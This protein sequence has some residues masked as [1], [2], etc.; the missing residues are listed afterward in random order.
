MERLY[1]HNVF[2]ISLIVSVAVSAVI[3]GSD[4][5]ASL[6]QLR[7]ASMEVLLLA[8]LALGLEIC[9]RGMRLQ[10]MTTIWQ[11]QVGFLR[12][13]QINLAG[14]FANAVT[15]A[16]VGG[17]PVRG[18]QLV[19]SKMTIEEATATIIG[20]R[21]TDHLALAVLSVVL[22]ALSFDSFEGSGRY[23]AYM[24]G[25]SLIGCVTCYIYFRG[26]SKFRQGTTGRYLGTLF[27]RLIGKDSLPGRYAL[28][29][30]QFWSRLR[31]DLRHMVTLG[32]KRFLLCGLLAI[33]NQS[34]RTCIP[35][36]LAYG[37][38]LD[39][40]VA[41]CVLWILAKRYGLDSMPIPGANG[42]TETA[43]LW[44]FG[45]Y[46][47]VSSL[48]PFLILWRFFSYYAYL[49]LG[50][51]VTVWMV[52]NRTSGLKSYLTSIGN[53]QNPVAEESA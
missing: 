25:A 2:I 9:L 33:L 1:R 26:N 23:L 52:G 43:F 17:G 10:V 45:K 5:E 48:A 44:Y 42:I 53:D 46:T 50:G 37:L 49:I 4:L 35:V 47:A 41:A 21:L 16:S 31:Q 29:F 22:L 13:I 36:I 6:V 20:E 12:A 8:P 40:P 18:Y 39:V 38:H 7:S 11:K 51:A 19:R 34:V 3:F 32:G 15:P 30:M 24:G 14:D 28:R 27:G